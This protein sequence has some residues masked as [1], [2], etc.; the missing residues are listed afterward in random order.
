M[1]KLLI[2]MMVI[3]LVGCTQ[4]QRFDLMKNAQLDGCAMKRM[5]ETKISGQTGYLQSLEECHQIVLIQKGHDLHLSSVDEK[6]EPAS[7]DHFTSYSGNCWSSVKDMVLDKYYPYLKLPNKARKS[8]VRADADEQYEIVTVNLRKYALPE[9]LK[10][11]DKEKL[12]MVR[13]VMRSGYVFGGD[14]LCSSRDFHELESIVGMEIHRRYPY[15][16]N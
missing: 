14:S 11:L 15:G 3:G 8:E 4:G 12:L 5:S 16:V 6:S 2:F 10:D 13:D 1:F 9:K 7:Q